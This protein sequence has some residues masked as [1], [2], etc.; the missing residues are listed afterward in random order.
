MSIFDPTNLRSY[1]GSSDLSRILQFVGECNL[2]TD[3]CCS[4]HPGDVGYN[5]MGD[6]IDLSLFD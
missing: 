1:N 5:R 2:L 4:L 3:F 6:V